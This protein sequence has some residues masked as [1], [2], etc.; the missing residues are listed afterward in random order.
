M[1]TPNSEPNTETAEHYL[2]LS[3]NYQ[4]IPTILE[5]MSLIY[6]LK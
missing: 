5:E 2:A 3:E 4:S 6:K 1:G